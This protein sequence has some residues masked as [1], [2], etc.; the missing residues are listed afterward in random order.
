MGVL[1]LYDSLQS[2]PKPKSGRF[3]WLWLRWRGL[4]SF[5]CS[6]TAAVLSRDV[7]SS[8][9]LSS[10]LFL[11]PLSHLPP[12]HS[13]LPFSFPLS[14]RLLQALSVS[15][16]R[17]LL[18]SESDSFAGSLSTPFPPHSFALSLKVGVSPSLNYCVLCLSGS[19][20]FHYSFLI[21]DSLMTISTTYS[22][23][24]SLINAI[25]NALICYSQWTHKYPFTIIL[26][27][28]EIDCEK[29]KWEVLHLKKGVF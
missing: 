28:R 17:V 14:Q 18:F 1:V 4:S 27:H 29:C 21:F 7:R 15:L 23:F 12:V 8:L 20:Y 11:S 10:L 16:G 2:T 6:P 22:V 26:V 13:L 25:Y 3:L 24:L 5:E 19:P 9:P